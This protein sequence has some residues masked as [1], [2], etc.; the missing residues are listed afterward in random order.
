MHIVSLALSVKKGTRK[1]PSAE[2]TLKPEHGVCG[3]AHAGPWHRQVSL[4]ANESLLRAKSRG[5]DVSYGDFAENIVTQGLDLL[6]LD[7]GAQ[8]L[9]GDNAL[10]EITQFGKTCRKKCAIYY[11]AGDCIMPREGVFARVVHGGI[12][13]IGDPVTV[14][15]TRSARM[16]AK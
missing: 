7:M 16:T 6:S 8:L 13:R 9:L 4:L 1:T 12:I 14:V 15:Q 10:I 3:D 11:Q 5:L 2:L